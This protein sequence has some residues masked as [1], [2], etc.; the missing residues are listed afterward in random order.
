MELLICG[1]AFVVCY[2]VI[3]LNWW[4]SLLIAL[5]F[6]VAI[7]IAMY[8]VGVP[9]LGIAAGIGALINKIKQRGQGRYREPTWENVSEP[10]EPQEREIPLSATAEVAEKH[11]D[12]SNTFGTWSLVLGIISLLFWAE[13]TGTVAIVLGVLQFRR[14]A[15]KRAIAGFTIG[16]VAIVLAVVANLLGLY[17]PFP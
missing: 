8:V 11:K 15:T 5:A 3:D 2:F 16:V 1:I 12:K 13:V 10:I 4:I 17:S 6:P 9:L 14:H 7:S